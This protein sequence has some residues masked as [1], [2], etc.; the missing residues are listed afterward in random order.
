MKQLRLVLGERSSE[1]IVG[2]SL[3][4]A[5][6]LFTGRHT[7]ILADE[8]VIRYHRGSFPDLP[9]IS[10]G[11]GER[12]KSLENT[13]SIY[14]EL[15]KLELDR[16]SAIIGIGGGITTDISG[17]I[18]STYLRG[19]P[20]GFV[21]TTLLS[22]V[23]AAIGGKN[24]VNLDGYKNMIG[25]IRQPDF[26]IC[27]LETLSTLDQ[28]EFI[29]G[30]S[31]IIKY[32][33]IRHPELF[34]YLEE[35]IEEGINKNPDV[36]QQ[37]V[38]ESVQCKIDVVSVDENETGVRKTLNFGHTFGHA[39]EKLYKV[40]HG[41]AVAVGMALAAK[42]SVNLGMLRPSGADRLLSLLRRSGL[43]D[44]IG[45]DADEVSDAM[46]KDKK[47]TG[48]KIQFILLEDIGHAVIK[49]IDLNE[50][51]SILHDLC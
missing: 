6:S 5:D 27:D 47:R 1:I 4:N 30:F 49:S 14:R 44:R 28:K 37:L 12:A 11:S 7:V 9:L 29:E 31:E 25:L 8:N 51:K 36:L 3:R 46:R 13:I 42:V 35:K 17:F 26:V 18:A 38:A 22:Q 34:S 20:F 21:A 32:G 23:D 2:G 43:P 15:M 45:F 10:I 50:T 48:E 19:I 40:T 16:S 24:G 41:E 33:A 39:F